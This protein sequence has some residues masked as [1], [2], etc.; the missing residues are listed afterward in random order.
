MV[1]WDDVIGWLREKG[2]KSNDTRLV[3]MSEELV[4]IRWEHSRKERGE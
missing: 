1:D 3:L 2:L 4:E